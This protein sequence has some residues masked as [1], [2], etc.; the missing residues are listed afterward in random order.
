MAIP[1]RII[2][3]CC[4]ATRLAAPLGPRNTMGAHL[5]ARHVEV[6]AAELM[7]W[8][9]ACMAKLKVMNSTMG[10]RPAIAAPPPTPAKP[11]SVIGVSITRFG[12]E[13]L[14]QTLR[15]LVRALIFGDFLAHD[16]DAALS[17][18]ISSAIASRSASRTV[19]LHH[20][21][22]FGQV[23]IGHGRRLVAG[24][25]LG[26]AVGLLGTAILARSGFGSLGH[27]NR[28]S[29]RRRRGRGVL[30]FAR[31][32]RDH[33]AD[34]YVIGALG[35]QDRGNRAFIHGFEFHRRLVGL[36]LGEDVAGLHG[37][38]FLDQPLGEGALF[39]RGRQRR[40]LEL[41]RHL[42]TSPP[43]RRYTIRPD[44]VPASA[45]Q[46]RRIR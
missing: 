37:V 8:S 15:D 24:E 43:A 16:E 19:S 12:A 10:L 40:H 21:G 25:L 34:F 4:A 5:A 23:G 26:A 28:S 6:L 27:F 30:A 44:R 17:R 45:R 9:I 22:A 38:A 41:N 14:Q 32:R 31:N 11:C 46:N 2:W 36:D 18:R 42:S 7:I 35:D 20:F 33:G 13:F 39:H 29:R 1:G 3:L